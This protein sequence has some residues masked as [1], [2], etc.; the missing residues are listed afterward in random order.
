MNQ[1]THGHWLLGRAVHCVFVIYDGQST[2]VHTSGGYLEVIAVVVGLVHNYV[3]HSTVLKEIIRNLCA[4][5][6]IN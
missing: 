2:S 4:Q 3:L 1:H 5:F 6:L